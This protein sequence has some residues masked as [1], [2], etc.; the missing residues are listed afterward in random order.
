M[1]DRANNIYGAEI[2]FKTIKTRMNMT[3]DRSG[4]PPDTPVVN[5]RHLADSRKFPP[6]RHPPVAAVTII[7]K[8]K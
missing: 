7:T 1:Y 2:Y 5:L 8:V 6:P 4:R 3:L